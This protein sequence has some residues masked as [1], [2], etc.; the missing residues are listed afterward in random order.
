MSAPMWES[1]AAPGVGALETATGLD[2]AKSGCPAVRNVTMPDLGWAS[3][4]V[5]F[6]VSPYRVPGCSAWLGRT[7]QVSPSSLVS[8]L[9][10]TF[11][12][13]ASS[14]VNP[15]PA[16]V[17]FWL[18]VT[19]MAA[20]MFFS[21]VP[22]AGLVDTRSR[23]AAAG[24]ATPRDAHRASSSSHRRS[25][26]GSVVNG[27]VRHVAPGRRGQRRGWR[28]HAQVPVGRR[29]R[30]VPPRGGGL[31]RQG[32]SP[33]PGH[34]AQASSVR[35]SCSSP[36]SLVCA[37]MIVWASCWACAFEPPAIAAWLIVTAP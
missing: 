26:S 25:P 33:R 28:W 21:T 29:W 11:A 34:R 9:D 2:L 19:V 7:F 13:R 23:W 16:G 6:Q 24:D 20:A 36:I 18:N 37:S 27:S 22:S 32:P 8:A 15:S 17:A 4:A 5:T 12:P 10:L 35:S 30:G 3:P 14:R 31:A 1:P